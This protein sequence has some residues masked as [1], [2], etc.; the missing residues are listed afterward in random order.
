MSLSALPTGPVSRMCP[1]ASGLVRD[2]ISGV[3][4]SRT[5]HGNNLF[6][7]TNG[8]FCGCSIPLCIEGNL[9]PLALK[10]VRTLIEGFILPC[11]RLTSY[12]GA[13]YRAP[14]AIG[15][16]Q[17]V[18]RLKVI[19]AGAMSVSFLSLGVPAQVA[20]SSEAIFCALPF[21]GRPR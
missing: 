4:A 6:A 8:D 10:S 15:G 21:A 17:K 5:P 9:C 3:L 19:C 16:A 7:P 13:V 12:S 2:I 20:F 14:S 11:T 18:I 1:R